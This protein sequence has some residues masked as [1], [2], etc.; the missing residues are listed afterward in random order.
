MNMEAFMA[1]SDLLILEAIEAL[2]PTG[3]YL[4]YAQIAAAMRL[5]CST[6]TVQRSIDRLIRTGKIARVDG[7]KKWGF[8]YECES[9]KARV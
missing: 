7:C 9:W 4:T 1:F 8:K 5:P 3:D 2:S 6:K